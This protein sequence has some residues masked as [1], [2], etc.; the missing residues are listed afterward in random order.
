MFIKRHITQPT[1][2]PQKVDNMM[3]K[4]TLLNGLK[5]MQQQAAAIRHGSVDK[6]K[7]SAAH[8]LMQENKEGANMA[9]RYTKDTGIP[10]PEIDPAN[11]LFWCA[12]AGLY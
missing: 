3:M 9:Y 4:E 11:F 10:I 2:H 12:K 7:L 6:V 8:K 1:I 5:G